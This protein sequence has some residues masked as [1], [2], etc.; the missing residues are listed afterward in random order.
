MIWVGGGV[1]SNITVARI[2]QKRIYSRV[3]LFISF[4][5]GVKVK[6]H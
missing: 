2:C 5:K 4:G 3:K 6:R 1:E